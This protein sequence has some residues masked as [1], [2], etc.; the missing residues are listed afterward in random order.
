MPKS[1]LP[2]NT[3]SLL[4]ENT[5]LSQAL[6]AAELYFNQLSEVIFSINE[7][8]ILTFL[9]PAWERMTGF[10]VEESLHKPITNYLYYDD[11]KKMSAAVLNSDISQIERQIEFRIITQSR[12]IR[13][14]LLTARINTTD[15]GTIQNITGSLIDITERITTQQALTA[16]EE[17]YELVASSFNDGI[18]DW[19]LTNDSVYFSPRWKEM[20]GYERDELS[21]VFSTWKNLIHPDDVEMTLDTVDKFSKSNKIFYESIHRLKH[22]DGSWVWILARGIAVRDSNNKPLRLFGS[23]TDM[24][25]LR[26]IEETLLQRTREVNNVVTVSPDGIVTFTNEGLVSSVNPA[27]LKITGF[28][29]NEL[30][31]ITRHQFDQKML[32]ISNPR[33]PYQIEIVHEEPLLMQIINSEYLPVQKTDIYNSGLNFQHKIPA[34]RT[35]H[36]TKYCLNNTITPTIMYFRDVTLETE[37]DRMKSEF[38]SVAAH[39]LRM[40]ISTMYGYCELLLNRE[41]DPLTKYD[42]LQTIYGQCSSVVEMIND[43]LDLARIE[44]GSK[45][46]SHFSLQPFIPIVKETLSSLKMHADF[47]KVEVHYFID[48]S[49][50][51]YAETDHIKRALVNVLSNAFKYSPSN[52]KV[53]LEIKQRTNDKGVEEIGVTVEDKGIGMSPQQVARLFERFWRADNVRDIVGSG[54]GMALVKEIVDFHQGEIE[55]ESMLGQGSKIGLWFPLRLTHEDEFKN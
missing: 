29:H 6:R 55:V 47:H 8:G 41:F 14:V 21:N 49:L 33:K 52:R 54:L 1:N 15:N 20:L 5:R 53:I 40:P 10:L 13:W 3:E 7:E 2:N 4:L 39:E 30:L 27:F 24:T 31:M 36:L 44:T 12:Q 35:L 25:R 50:L 32:E 22:K 26:T 34:Y 48:E 38:L 42:I 16:S 37:M 11:T 17:R 19:D 18:W 23:H 43:L 9:N 51:I 46:F 45:Q 28:K